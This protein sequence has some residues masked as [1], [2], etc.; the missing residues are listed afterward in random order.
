[1]KQTCE[2]CRFSYFP[3]AEKPN[4]NQHGECRESSPVP[5]VVPSQHKNAIGEVTVVPM[6]QSVFPPIEKE[7]WCA[8]FQGGGEIPEFFTSQQDQANKLR[9]IRD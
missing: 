8:K 2:F 3:N 6:I 7:T 9:G 1:M 4:G 5:V